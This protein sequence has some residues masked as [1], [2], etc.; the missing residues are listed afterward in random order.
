MRS[1]EIRSATRRNL[2]RNILALGLLP[3]PTLSWSDVGDIKFVTGVRNLN[4]SYAIVG[5][6]NAYEI[7]FNIEVQSR[8]HSAAYHPISAEAVVFSRRPGNFALV[9]DCN[10]GNI[11]N[12]LTLSDNNHFYGHGCFSADGSFLYTSENEISSGHGR[13]GIWNSNNNY[14]RVDQYSSGGI[15]PH[16]IV[17]LNEPDSLVIANGGIRTHPNTGRKKLNLDTMSSNISI[18]EKTGKITQTFSLQDKYRLNSIRHLT[19]CNNSVACG[20]QWQGDHFEA[21]PLMAIL[22]TKN[23]KLRLIN[24]NEGT[25]RRMGG[26]IGSISFSK[27]GNKLCCTSPSSNIVSVYDFESGRTQQFNC[28][29]ASGVAPSENGFL[30]SS[31]IGKLYSID[32]EGINLVKSHHIS[33][34]NHLISL[35]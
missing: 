27:D 2:I 7:L 6:N 32:D 13:V 1:M 16:E 18:M 5:I 3:M 23:G 10:T 15:G 29:D 34:D 17:T 14:T 33:F 30:I 31:G 4:N 19:V 8:V 24:Q 25:R 35:V 28:L 12:R 26:Y 20:F 21:P 22:F 11:K 9:I